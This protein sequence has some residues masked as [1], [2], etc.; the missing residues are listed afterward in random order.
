MNYQGIRNNQVNLHEF[1]S[2]GHKFKLKFELLRNFE[3]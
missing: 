1:S 3:L 2:L